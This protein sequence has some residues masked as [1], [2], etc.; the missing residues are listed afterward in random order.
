[1]T[2]HKILLEGFSP[3]CTENTI[4]FHWTDRS[5]ND[6]FVGKIAVCCENHDINTLCGQNVVVC[7]KLSGTYAYH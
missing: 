1:M 7:V 2:Q 5:V 3:Y 4:S 6:L